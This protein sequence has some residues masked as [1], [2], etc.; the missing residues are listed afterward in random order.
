M[1]VFGLTGGIACG[2]SAIAARF[3]ER[4]V[5]VIDTDLLAREVVAK[6]TGGLAAVVRELG[7]GVLAPDGSLDRAAVGSIVFADA[8]KRKVLE[9]ITHPLIAAAGLARGHELARAGHPLA[10]YEAALIVENG[11]ADSFRPLV[12]V[13]APDNVQIARILARDGLDEPAARAR[14]AAQRTNA[15]KVLVADLVID[16]DGTLADLRRKTDDA[17]RAICTR[18]EVDPARYGFC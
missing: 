1:H 10:C 16:N 7:P 12:V 3:A 17:L 5:P 15:Q 14:I 4:G 2:K 9:A 8:S 18:T 11:L 13:V 6:N